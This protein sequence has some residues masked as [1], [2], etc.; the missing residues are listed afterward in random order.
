MEQRSVLR[1]RRSATVLV[2]TKHEYEHTRTPH[3]AR[4]RRCKPAWKRRLVPTALILSDVLLALLFWKVAS[5]LQGLWSQEALSAEVAVV[6]MVPVIA[7]WVG[8]RALL[9]L[10]PGY[11]LDSVEHLRRHV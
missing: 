8:L 4:T 11:G 6:T 7:V 2:P 9:G 3:T 1:G 5:V 10:Y